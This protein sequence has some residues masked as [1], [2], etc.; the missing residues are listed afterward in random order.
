MNQIKL[1]IWT[2][3]CQHDPYNSFFFLLRQPEPST[4]KV[5]SSAPVCPENS[6]TVQCSFLR[7]FQNKSSL[8]DDSLICFSLTSNNSHA[9]INCTLGNGDNKHGNC[10]TVAA[11]NCFFNY[12]A[13]FSSCDAWTHAVEKI[14]SNKSKPDIAG[15]L[16]I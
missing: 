7:D 5:P 16:F 12:S 4:T 15:N 13:N 3:I 8:T 1:C 14:N 9:S 6:V 10:E 11:T 2:S